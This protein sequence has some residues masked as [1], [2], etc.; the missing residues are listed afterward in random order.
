MGAAGGLGA[1]GS[2]QLWIGAGDRSESETQPTQE[3]DGTTFSWWHS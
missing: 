1:E 2:M 3:L